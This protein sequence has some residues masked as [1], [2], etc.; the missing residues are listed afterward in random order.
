MRRL[1]FIGLEFLVISIAVLIAIFDMSKIDYLLYIGVPLII[2][3]YI[4]FGFKRPIFIQS[5]PIIT[6]NVLII[7]SLFLSILGDLIFKANPNLANILD[8]LSIIIDVIWVFMIILLVLLKNN[9]LR[10]KKKQALRD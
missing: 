7:L 5:W 9:V 10:S 6:I 2:L 3:I 1:L 4:L 8:T